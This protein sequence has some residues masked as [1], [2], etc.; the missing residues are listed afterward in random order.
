LFD[1]PEA[2]ETARLGASLTASNGTVKLGG[3]RLGRAGLV[4][5]LRRV[6]TLRDPLYAGHRYPAELIGYAVWLFFR[7]PLSLRMVEEMLAVRGISVTY[8]TIRV[9]RQSG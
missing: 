2:V 8:A 9:A 4:A 5:Y 6:T 3:L 1:P 7:F